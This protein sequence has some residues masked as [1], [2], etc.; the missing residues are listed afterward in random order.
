MW[1]ELTTKK[2]KITPK[3]HLKLRAVIFKIVD[4]ENSLS[5]GEGQPTKN[6]KIADPPYS[7]Y[8]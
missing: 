1:P 7:A 8:F 4:F 5:E 3:K 6:Q 2:F